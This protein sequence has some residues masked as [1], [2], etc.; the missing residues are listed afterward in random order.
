MMTKQQLRQVLENL[1]KKHS[2][3]NKD[4]QNPE[5]SGNKI[6][7]DDA[8][9]AAA[10][11]IL[12]KELGTLNIG[13]DLELMQAGITLTGWHIENG[14]RSFAS[15]SE[16]MMADLGDLVKPY[17]KSWYMAVAF[18]PA[19]AGFDG[20]DSA[21]TV[22]SFDI[23][24]LD[25]AV[26]AHTMKIPT[27]Q[28]EIPAFKAWVDAE[29]TRFE[30]DQNETWPVMGATNRQQEM[31]AYWRENRPQMYQLLLREN[32]LTKLAYVLECL[33]WEQEA[34]NRATGVA[35]PD[36]K[37]EAEKDWLIMEPEDGPA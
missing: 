24:A 5:P 9:A 3:N 4:K 22:D 21:A 13:L 36:S 28:A 23:K 33:M 10:R 2:Q 17:L 19:A 20:M 29:A 35:W 27:I 6:F 14:A 37:S 11:E 25:T 15:Y 31:K 1:I 32:L 34:K 30:E 26:E 18:D 7:T 16:A 12:K 8:A